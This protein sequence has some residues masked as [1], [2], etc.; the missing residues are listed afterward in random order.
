MTEALRLAEEAGD[1]GE[2]PVGAVCVLNGEIIGR[3]RN[4]REEFNDPLG[5][6]E[7][8][9]IKEASEFLGTWRLTGVHLYVTLEP[10]PMCAGAIVNSRIERVIFGTEDLNMGACGSAVNIMKIKHAFSPK[11][12]RGFMEDECRELLK[13]FFAKLRN[14]FPTAKIYKKSH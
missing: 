8:M 11:I 10:C 6:A 12:F 5:H 3:G 7:I 13:R 1:R 14:K 9:A 4:T 2:I